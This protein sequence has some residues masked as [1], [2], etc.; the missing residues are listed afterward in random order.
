LDEKG[1]RVVLLWFWVSDI[2]INK[3]KPLSTQINLKRKMD[4]PLNEGLEQIAEG[5]LEEMEL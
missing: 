1:C 4:S 5:V 2:L 3:G